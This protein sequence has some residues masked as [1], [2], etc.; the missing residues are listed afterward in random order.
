M[1]IRAADNNETVT[2]VLGITG[3]KVALP[4]NITPPVQDDAVALILWY[5]DDITK[6]IYSVDARKTS[7]DQARHVTGQAVSSRVSLS[8]EDN[9]SMLYL[10]F[11]TEED[12]GEYRCRVDF[13]RAR[14]RN[15]IVFLQLVGK[16]FTV[17][18]VE[19]SFTSFFSF[20]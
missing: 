14:S 20:V 11:L 1:E 7:V 9:P 2:S 18:N 10:E 4:C 16:Y 6:P 8:L 19:V 12:E 15:G 5:K 3:S 17:V 13:R